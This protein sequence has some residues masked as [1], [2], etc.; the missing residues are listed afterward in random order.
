MKNGYRRLM[1]ITPVLLITLS[2][3]GANFSSIY[4]TTGIEESKIVLIDAKQRAII[5]NA[6][7]TK[8]GPIVCAEESP[9]VFSVLSAAFGA[10][11]GTEA[12]SAAFSAATSETGATTKLSTQLSR[13][14]RSYLYSLCQ[15]YSND[16]IGKSEFEYQMRRI[17]YTLVVMLAIEQLTGVATQT[18]VAISA[19]K[20][21]SEGEATP[22]PP[23]DGAEQQ[24]VTPSPGDGAEQQ[25]GTLS[26]DASA[27]AGEGVQIQI[28]KGGHVT[29]GTDPVATQA[30]ATAVTE[31]VDM[32]LHQGQITE[33][34]LK[35]LGSDDFKFERDD[36]RWEVCKDAIEKEVDHI[37]SVKETS[38]H[39]ASPSSLELMQSD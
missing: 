11:G 35:L 10:S 16:S 24:P 38:H 30:I 5:I 17:P 4:R 27:T 32:F 9:D 37:A 2:G 21:T 19:G 15:A 39:P 12:M 1:L 20:S 13:A 8:S 36:P 25:P 28:E 22:T 3:C 23:G 33:T 14:Q 18:T 29:L 7:K 34:C 6:G 26:S 31:I